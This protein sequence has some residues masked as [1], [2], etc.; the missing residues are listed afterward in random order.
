MSESATLIVTATPNPQ[1]MG[2]VQEYLKGVMPLFLS[3][4][5]TLVRRLKVESVLLGKPAGMVLVMDFP[6]ADAIRALF[7]SDAY[8]ALVEIRD[9]GFVETNILVTQSM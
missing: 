7:A 4:G 6:S 5:G 2:A 3:A 8:G 1:E 9:R